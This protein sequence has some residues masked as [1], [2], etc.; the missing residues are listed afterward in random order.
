M[1]PESKNAGD[2][3]AEVQTAGMEWWLFKNEW[4]QDKQ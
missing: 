3:G 4:K 2:K 1:V